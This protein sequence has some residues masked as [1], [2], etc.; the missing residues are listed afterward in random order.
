MKSAARDAVFVVCSIVPRLLKKVKKKKKNMTAPIHNKDEPNKL[1]A[2]DCD[3]VAVP[4]TP[5][6]SGDW[7]N[8]F[9]LL[10]LYTMQGMPLG[11]AAAIPIVLQSN[12]NVTYKDQVIRFNP[13]VPCQYSVLY[14]Y[15]LGFF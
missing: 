15:F 13:N 7:P 11:L 14:I 4:D 2:K 12:K 1:G 3:S 5:N 6:L 9:L 8:F 10:L